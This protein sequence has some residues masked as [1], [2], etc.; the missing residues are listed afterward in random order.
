MKLITKDSVSHILYINQE[1][2]LRY[3][4]IV[5]GSILVIQMSIKLF[6]AF[7]YKTLD[8]GFLQEEEK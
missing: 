6:W 4:V 5:F 3:Q 1:R 8:A 7:S 2:V